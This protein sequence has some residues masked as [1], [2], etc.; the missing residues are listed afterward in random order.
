[1][2]I[3][4]A[5]SPNMKA[6][7][8]QIVVAVMTHIAVVEVLRERNST[9][10][11]TAEIRPNSFQVAMAQM[12]LGRDFAFARIAGVWSNR[13]QMLYDRISPPPRGKVD[14]RLSIIVLSKRIRASFDPAPN[15]L[16]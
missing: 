12:L 11:T 7:G 4:Q 6:S 13:S 15:R 9:F 16:H 8:A 14:G 1:M 2:P 10:A 5:L 3:L